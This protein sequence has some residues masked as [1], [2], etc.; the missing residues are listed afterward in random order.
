MVEGRGVCE[1]A[2][3]RRLVRRE[4]PYLEVLAIAGVR[5]GDAVL[6]AGAEAVTA[7]V[8]GA[9][10]QRDE[11]LPER[12]R[13]AE[14]G[15]DA[16]QPDAATLVVGAHTE[17]AKPQDRGGVDVSPSADHMPDDLT[18]LIHRHERQLR[19]PALAAVQFVQ[20]RGLGRDRGPL[21]GER[22]CSDSAYGW[23]VGG[24][25]ASDQHRH[26]PGVGAARAQR[27]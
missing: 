26:S 18:P 10:E 1:G 20:Q 14:H 22:G 6:R 25:F 13:R 3:Q 4:G 12:V 27:N 7:V 21:L 2:A 8:R 24:R 19:Q 17:R 11:R 16:R 23:N 5:R 15:V 9:A